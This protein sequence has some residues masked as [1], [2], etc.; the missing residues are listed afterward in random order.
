MLHRLNVDC[1]RLCVQYRFIEC[2]RASGARLLLEGHRTLFRVG[3]GAVAALL[4]A[5][6]ACVPTP[7]PTT[8]DSSKDSSVGYFSVFVWQRL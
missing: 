8:K 3:G 2:S 5:G 1:L 6:I 7:L 4:A